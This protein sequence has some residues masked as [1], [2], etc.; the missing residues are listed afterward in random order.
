MAE[1]NCGFEAVERHSTAFM[2]VLDFSIPIQAPT[3]ALPP[4]FFKFCA[5]ALRF[6]YLNS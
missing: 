5:F 6:Y 3:E 4:L 2:Y 1:Q